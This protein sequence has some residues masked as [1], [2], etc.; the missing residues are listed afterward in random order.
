MSSVVRIGSRGS[1]LA[2]AQTGWVRR[3][4]QA[5]FPDVQF[6]LEIIK[7]TGDRLAVDPKLDS[8]LGKGLFTKEIE[9]ALLDKRIDLAVHSYKD[10]PTDETAGLVI[11]AVPERADAR[12]VLIARKTETVATLKKEARVATGSPRRQAQIRWHRPDIQCEPIR[13]NIDTRIRKLKKHPEWDAL[14]LAKAGLD[15][16]KPDLMGLVATEIEFSEMLPAPGQ[17][18]LAIQTRSGD[19]VE[20]MVKKIDHEETR[21]TVLA[22]RSFLE[23]L[24][25]GCQMPFA[26]RASWDEGRLCLEGICWLKGEEK[27]RRGSLWAPRE[28][29]R[30]L[31]EK[32]ARQL[33]A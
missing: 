5:R 25:G 14:V 17:G 31:G 1:G 26:A 21:L 3:E 7:T 23:A 18:A 19:P 22:E 12:D 10:L 13:G 24:G 11:A 33:Q 6:E 32:L 8:P 28:K 29:A 27:P 20:A 9:Q 4:L 16:L 2:L 30:E 15:R